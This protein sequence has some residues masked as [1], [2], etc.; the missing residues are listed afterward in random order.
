MILEASKQLILPSRSQYIWP[1]NAYHSLL[2][3]FLLKQPA[4]ETVAL[5]EQSETI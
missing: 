5:I 4:L 3:S 2:E 1:Y